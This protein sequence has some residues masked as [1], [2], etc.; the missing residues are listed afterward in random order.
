MDT[1]QNSQRSKASNAVIVTSSRAVRAVKS[2]RGLEARSL[3][4]ATVN[5]LVFIEIQFHIFYFCRENMMSA[6]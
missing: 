6:K 2:L 5:L 1:V 4:A 3:V